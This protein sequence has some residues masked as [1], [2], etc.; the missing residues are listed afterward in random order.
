M[1]RHSWHVYIVECADGSLYTGI[2]IDVD[3]RVKKHNEGTASKYTRSRLPVKLVYKESASDRGAASRREAEI[4]A[5]TRAQ[6]SALISAQSRSKIA[7]LR[8]Q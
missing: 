8:S 4:K 6:K 3:E 5:L 2:A 7:S 1:P